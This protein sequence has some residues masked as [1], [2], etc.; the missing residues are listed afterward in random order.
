MYTGFWCGNLKER[1]HTEDP[2]IHGRII[3]RWITS[4]R[5]EIFTSS[6]VNSLLLN[7]VTHLRK[8]DSDMTL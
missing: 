5:T 8:Q 7:V 1:D 6:S 2:G 3:L 4:E